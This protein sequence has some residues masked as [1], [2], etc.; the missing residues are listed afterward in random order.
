MDGLTLL[1]NFTQAILIAQ[2]AADA[3]MGSAEPAA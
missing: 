3:Q 2:A 1:E